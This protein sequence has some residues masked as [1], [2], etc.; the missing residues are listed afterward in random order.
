M[1]LLNKLANRIKLC[2]EEVDNRNRSNL[3]LFSQGAFLLAAIIICVS[4]VLPYY[5]WML[6]PHVTLL[7][8]TAVLF[9]L[10]KYCK[11]NKVKHIRALQYLLFAPLLIGGVLVST[12]LDPTSQ[13]ITIILFICILPLFMIDN[14]W[15][16]LSYQLFFA[17][18]F[19]IFAFYFKPYDVF[20][21]DMLYLPIYMAYIMGVTIFA[22]MEKIAGVENYLLVRK[23][24]ERDTLTELLNRTYGE[25]KVSQLLQN[26][27]RG[28]FAILDIDDFKL[29]NDKYGHQ[30]GDKVLC[31]VSE[32]MQTVFRADDV[33]WRL[34][35]DEFA[36]YAI[37]LTDPDTCRQRFGELMKLLENVELT[38]EIIVHVRISIGCTICQSDGPTFADLYKVSDDA[39]YE[40]KNNG[41][42][43]LIV[44][45]L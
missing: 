14:P 36:I 45:T 4:L 10:A 8:Y 13:G 9:F 2:S 21:S 30:L 17:V 20:M 12:V 18:L 38:Q 6:A 39:L 15:R 3:I 44:K 43:Q 26:N 24:A 28:S 27:I 42:G 40:S 41:K 5:R 37:K 1:I 31:K 19:V 29:F 34:G 35:G 11:K 7:V 33:L 32:A 22:L 23:T 25:I 16:I